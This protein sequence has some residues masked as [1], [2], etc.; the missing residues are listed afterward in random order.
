MSEPWWLPG[1]T[2]CPLEHCLLRLGLSHKET[3]WSVVTWSI[4]TEKKWLKSNALI[5][6]ARVEAS[7]TSPDRTYLG[8]TWLDSISIL[9]V[10]P[11]YSTHFHAFAMFMQQLT[12]FAPLSLSFFVSS[13]LSLVIS[14]QDHEALSS[15]WFRSLR[16]VCLSLFVLTQPLAFSIIFLSADCIP[17]RGT[18]LQTDPEAES[19]TGSTSGSQPESSLWK[20]NTSFFWQHH[21]ARSLSQQMQKSSSSCHS[22]LWQSR[23]D[24]G[25]SLS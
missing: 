2:R 5:S 18:L 21:G 9:I 22:Q 6:W 15:L 10:D 11:C 4:F 1:R 14:G 20:E 25:H 16:C 3:V 13:K 12:S 23:A 24:I 8:S 7:R 19:L 17:W